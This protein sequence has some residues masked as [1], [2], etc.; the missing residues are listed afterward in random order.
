MAIF[1]AFAAII[2]KCSYASWFILV[3]KQGKKILQTVNKTA[4]ATEHT[5]VPAKT[6]VLG[7]RS[8]IPASVAFLEPVYLAFASS[9]NCCY[10]TA[11]PCRGSHCF[12]YTQQWW[13]HYCSQ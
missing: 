8:N 12:F 1:S 5:Q 13:S 7:R 4:I 2:A 10:Q 3:V 6:L 9:S 11:A